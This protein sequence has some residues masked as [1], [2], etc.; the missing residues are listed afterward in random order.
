MKLDNLVAEKFLHYKIPYRR[1]LLPDIKCS[2][3][4]LKKS[5]KLVLSIYKILHMQL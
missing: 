3:K 4:N 2:R 5:T 1:A